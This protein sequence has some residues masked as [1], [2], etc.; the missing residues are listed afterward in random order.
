EKQTFMEGFSYALA[1][2]TTTNTEFF[3]N[4]PQNAM[5]EQ[6]LVWDSRMF[7]L[8]GEE[9]FENLKSNSPSHFPSPPAVPLAGAGPFQNKDVQL[10]LSGTGTCG[11]QECALIDYRAFFNTFELKLPKETLIG[12]S[13]YWGQVWVSLATKRLVRATL[14]EDVLGE[15][16]G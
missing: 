11:D 5:Q 16:T 13:H 12:R 8:F 7:E 10:L 15:V 6:N 3:R 1:A 9:Q 14:Y 4:F 2:E